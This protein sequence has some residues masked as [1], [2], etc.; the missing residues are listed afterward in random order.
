MDSRYS[1]MRH[2]AE[3]R[4]PSMRHY[5]ELRVPCM[6]YHAELQDVEY[7]ILCGIVYISGQ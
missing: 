2:Y 5:A 1:I 4:V 6:R 3:L 7:A